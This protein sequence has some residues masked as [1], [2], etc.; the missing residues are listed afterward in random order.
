[1]LF[2][3]GYTCFISFLLVFL[4]IL[5][6][7]LNLYRSYRKSSVFYCCCNK[8]LKNK[9][10]CVFLSFF[11]SQLLFIFMTCSSL[12]VYEIYSFWYQRL[13]QSNFPCFY[14]QFCSGQSFLLTAV[15]SQQICGRFMRL[16]CTGHFNIS[17]LPCST[18]R[19]SY[20]ACLWKLSHSVS[21]TVLK[22]NAWY[23]QIRKFHCV[24]FTISARCEDGLNHKE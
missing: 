4:K 13:F 17:T 22:G 24:F 8:G 11:Q 19:A 18:F 1:M 14:Q 10:L 5:G 23:T 9:T 6:N 21:F 3:Q 2:S 15:A 12:V 16:A 7:F 20:V